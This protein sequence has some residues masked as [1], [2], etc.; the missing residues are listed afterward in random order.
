MK[1]TLGFGFCALTLL[2]YP[3][4]DHPA[5]TPK[6]AF[7]A[8]FLPAVLISLK[9]KWSP[10]HWIALAF[11]GWCWFTLFWAFPME[12]LER[13]ATLSITALAYM[14]GAGLRPS[15]YK[16]AVMGFGLG[17]AINIIPFVM[18][19][20][21][22]EIVLHGGSPAGM[23][24]NQTFFGE[25][26]AVAAVSFW[27]FAILVAVGGAKAPLVALL[28]LVALRWRWL[29]LL[30]PLG[31]FIEWNNSVDVRL[32]LWLNALAAFADK[33]WGWGIGSFR[34]VYALYHD[35]VL[36]SHIG[37]FEFTIRPRTAHNEYVT[38]LVETG[39][40]GFGLFSWLLFELLSKGKGHARL[41]LAIV[42]LLGL[43]NFPLH[44]PATAVFG[45]LAAGHLSRS[46]QHLRLF[47]VFRRV[48]LLPGADRHGRKA[49]CGGLSP[50]E[51]GK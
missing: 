40:I 14:A 49:P 38:L 42:A 50:Y 19:Y 46:R 11:F 30:A 2:Y 33:P 43:F 6:W 8:V 24:F 35:A 29:L 44:V 4:L 17:V 20:Y 15:Y 1:F 25:A 27:P 31:L 51:H 10:V 9:I 36:P 48:H 12:A 37:I 28:M 22:S 34:S 13:L 5:S 16:A 7:M 45:A 23:F 3:Y 32:Q 21:G 39:I 18:Q 26:A 47:A 41:I